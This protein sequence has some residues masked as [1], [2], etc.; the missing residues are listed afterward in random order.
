MR[1]GRESWETLW[2]LAWAT[3]QHFVSHRLSVQDRQRCSCQTEWY[4]VRVRDIRVLETYFGWDRAHSN[5]RRAFSLHHCLGFITSEYCIV[6]K[7]IWCFIISFFK[8]YQSRRK[9]LPR[10]LFLAHIFFTYWVLPETDRSSL[11]YK[12]RIIL[13]WVS[14]DN[15]VFFVGDFL[16]FLSPLCSLHFV[17][18]TDEELLYNLYLCS[19][20]LRNFW[21]HF[22]DLE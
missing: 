9:N 3:L 7:Y 17:P 5:C 2:A 8:V 20:G 15:L 13:S 4:L 10:D 19:E 16:L 11:S 22:W 6:E 21:V 14:V 1:V 18:S 12:K